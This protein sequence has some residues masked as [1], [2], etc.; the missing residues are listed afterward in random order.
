MYGQASVIIAKILNSLNHFFTDIL[1]KTYSFPF[2]KKKR[3]SIDSPHIKTY[4]CLCIVRFLL[5]AILQRIQ[6]EILMPDR[7]ALNIDHSF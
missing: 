7:H 1:N 5:I 2:M 6:E 4:A 3:E